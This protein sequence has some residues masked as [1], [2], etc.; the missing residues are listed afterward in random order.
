M[1]SGFF[2][3]ARFEVTGVFCQ[4]AIDSAQN[5]HATVVQ[6]ILANKEMH[7]Q[8]IRKL[9]SRFDQ[10]ETGVITFAMLEEKL[11]SSE[12]REYFETLGLDVWDAWTFFKLLDLD[13]GLLGR[14]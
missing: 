10:Q 3:F 4:S 2:F 1:A 5:D 14:T 9:F 12:V 11:D 6:S 8:K 7:V 13:A